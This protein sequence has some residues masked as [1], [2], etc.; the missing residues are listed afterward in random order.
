MSHIKK[1]DLVQIYRII[2]KC[3]EDAAMGYTFVAKDPELLSLVSCESCNTYFH[4]V[5]CVPSPI[6]PE[7]YCPCDTLR[8]IP[9]PHELGLIDEECPY[10]KELETA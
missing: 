8:K 4:D 6:S 2:C 9:P 10:P 5:W 1:G 7:R 3:S